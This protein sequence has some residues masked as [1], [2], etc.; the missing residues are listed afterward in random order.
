MISIINH[1]QMDSRSHV[2][3]SQLSFEFSLVL[4]LKKY[5]VN[6]LNSLWLLLYLAPAWYP[7]F[8]PQFNN[9]LYHEP[10]TVGI[11]GICKYKRKRMLVQSSQNVFL[12]N[13]SE[14]VYFNWALTVRC[15]DGKVTQLY[16]DA[17]EPQLRGGV[18][19]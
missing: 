16:Y 4:F 3:F 7:V 15:R 2:D 19:I 9:V 12:I 11:N 18:V 6:F 8:L 5:P 14:E 17:R 1:N 13:N 10:N